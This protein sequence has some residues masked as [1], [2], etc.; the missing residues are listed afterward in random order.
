M[1]KVLLF[2]STIIA[3]YIGFIIGA[4]LNL[5][6]YLG[7]VFAIAVVGIFILDAIEKK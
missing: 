4:A 6:G 2:I 7:I 1:K 5:E 3:A